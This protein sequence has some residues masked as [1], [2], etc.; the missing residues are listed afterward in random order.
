M[1]IPQIDTRR[2]P[3]QR[4]NSSQLLINLPSD[5]PFGN[6]ML[7]HM[8]IIDRMDRVNS[9]IE[10][11]FSSYSSAR[12]DDEKE[13]LMRHQ[14]IIEE[15]VY[16]LRKTADELIGMQYVLYVQKQKGTFP[17]R[18]EIDCIDSLNNSNQ[19]NFKQLFINHIS[20]LGMLNEVSNAYKHSFL[21]SDISLVGNL[22]PYVFALSLK[23]NNL[24]K[25]PVFHAYSFRSLIEEFNKFFLNSKEQLREY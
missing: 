20:L 11:V 10:V 7:K 16:W 13:D 5:T 21:N 9:S 17:K 23:R 14:F 1:N 22:E 25:Q 4:L 12:I 8:K 3:Q 6:L 15:V 2:K 19:E 18:V 24:E